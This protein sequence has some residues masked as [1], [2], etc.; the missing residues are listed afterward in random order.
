MRCFLFCAKR[1]TTEVGTNEGPSLEV[2]ER[3]CNKESMKNKEMKL[4]A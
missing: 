1:K 4:K 2:G 3:I